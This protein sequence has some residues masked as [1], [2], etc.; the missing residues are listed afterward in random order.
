M[1]LLVNI[2]GLIVFVGLA[3]LFSK[4]SRRLNGVQLAL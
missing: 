1:Y 4:K 3:F 2:I